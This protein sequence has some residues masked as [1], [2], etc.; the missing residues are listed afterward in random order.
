MLENLKKHW[1]VVLVALVFVAGTIYFV[2]D[3]VT[4]TVSGKKVDGKDV[5]FSFDNINYTA[6]ELYESL[7]SGI[8]N[9][10]LA[11][12]FEQLVVNQTVTLSDDEIT[13]AKLQ[14]EDLFDNYTIQY[15]DNTEAVLDSIMQSIG[16]KDHT[17]LQKYFEFMMAREKVVS[18]YLEANLDDFWSDYEEKYSPRLASHILVSIK[19]FDNITDDEQAKMDAIE[20]A[21]ANGDKFEDVAKEYSDDG[22]AS[23]G[24]ALGFVSSQTNFVK[25]FKE[26]VLEQDAGEVSEWVK[27]EFGFHII[28]T[29]ATD[30]ESLKANTD[31]N[32]HFIGANPQIQGNA[33]WQEALKLEID[34]KGNE[35]LEDLLK[36]TLGVKELED[37][38]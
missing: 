25:E 5:V 10:L 22:S 3:S 17:E 38:E 23:T 14:A 18:E 6:D 33:I 30:Y 8:G 27:S 26:V 36:A 34:Y 13:D 19:D 31:F 29:T 24:G 1:F 20:A 7:E 35:E 16:F 15:G 37:A 32:D 9:S 28:Y 12:T 2:Q 21:L 11:M 4:A